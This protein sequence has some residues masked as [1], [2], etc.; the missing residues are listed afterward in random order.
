M[1]KGSSG[2]VRVFYPEIDGEKVIEILRERIQELAKKL[3][4]VKAVLIGSYAKRSYT[5]RSDIDLLI[6]YQDEERTDAY[7]IVKRTIGLPRLE[8]HLYTLTQY[9]RFRD[10]LTRMIEGGIVLVP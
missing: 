8:P 9:Q 1:Q 3:P 4:L 2:S 10:R 7:A 5:V 6:V